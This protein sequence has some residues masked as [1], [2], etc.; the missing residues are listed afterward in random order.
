ML[1]APVG[2]NDTITTT[3]DVSHTFALEDFGFSDVDGDSLDGVQIALVESAGD[4]EYA[5]VDVVQGQT[6]TDVTQLVFTPVVNMNGTPYATFNFK[7]EDSGG[8]F[9]DSVYQ[10]R[11]NVTPVADA[12][13][14]A[15][16]T[17]T[18]T[19][20]ISHT[21]STGDLNFGDVDV[22]D[23]LVGVWITA[24]ESAGDLEYAGADVSAGNFYTGMTQLVFTPGADENGAPPLASACKTA[25]G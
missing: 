3:E 21:F 8:D 13:L 10:M 24:E 5:G 9:S 17:L 25:P 14:G 7:L 12:P 4:L 20:D 15:S 23:T 18:L 1:D 2:A 22:G 11:I 16:S 6:Y 19:E